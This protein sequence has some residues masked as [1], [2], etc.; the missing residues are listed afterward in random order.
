MNQATSADETIA[1]CMLSNQSIWMEFSEDQALVARC[2]AGSDAAFRELVDR[3]KDLVFGLISR[4]VID[5][6]RTD[7]LAQEVFLK[8]HRGLPYFRGEARLSTWIYR[9]VL[10]VCA[11]ERAR[12]SV[13]ISLD[14]FGAD[15]WPRL[16]P[17]TIDRSYSDLELRDRLNKAL[18]RL[19]HDTRFL[20]TA[21]YL[22]GRKYEEL[23]DVLGVPLGT[24]KTQLH[25]AKRR[26]RELLEHDSRRSSVV[27]GQSH[28]QD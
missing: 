10:N 7:D 28:H 6:S 9:I 13:E 11:D 1:A 17:G 2:R 14:T 3:Y 22:S 19:P 12:R 23:A 16:D 15:G 21:H 18:A 20:I 4:T 26:L 8:V 27:S 25:R 5:R 24:V